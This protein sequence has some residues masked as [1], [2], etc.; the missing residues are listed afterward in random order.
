MVPL[1]CVVDDDDASR[2]AISGLV[3]AL[4]HRVAE[5]SSAD[6]FLAFAEIGRVEVLIADVRMPGMTGIELCELMAASGSAIRT[7]L[8]TAH[9][10]EADRQ[11]AARVGA[12]FLVKPVSP[13]ALAACLGAP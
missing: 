4:G 1:I 2:E 11:G 8:V 5:F 10:S 6:A 3:R 13:A 9:P 7:V 12:A